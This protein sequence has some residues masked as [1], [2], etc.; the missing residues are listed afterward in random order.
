MDSVIS[1]HRHFN[2][3]VFGVIALVL[4]SGLLLMATLVIVRERQSTRYPGAVTVATQNHVVLFPYHYSRDTTYRVLGS[5]PDVYDWYATR[6]ELRPDRITTNGCI[7][8]G[9]SERY[10]VVVRRMKV[11]LCNSAS[12]QTILVSRSTLVQ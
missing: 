10:V 9:G 8:L 11:M 1:R 4:V 2:A 3:W 12:G 5:F 7:V 6:F